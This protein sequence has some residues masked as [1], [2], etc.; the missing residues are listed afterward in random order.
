MFERIKFLRHF[1]SGSCV[2]GLLLIGVLALGSHGQINEKN[3]S[4]PRPLQP[5]DQKKLPAEVET[6]NNAARKMYAEARSRELSTIP[7]V[8]LVSGDDLILRK[9]GLRTA[10]TTTPIAVHLLKSV[11]HSTLALFTHL[12]SEPG[13]PL[14]KERLKTLSEYQALMAAAILPLERFGLEPEL[15]ARQKRILARAQEFAA[16]VL[17][18]GS[19]SAS[20]L[21]MFCR[22][23]RAD[24]MANG[25][26]AA[27][28]QMVA[29]HK[30][31]LIWKQAMTPEEW[32][33]VAVVVSGSQT[34]RA[35]NAA[36]QY[37]ARLFG[38]SSGESRR[39]VYAES[40]WDEDKAINL[41][42]TLRLDGK[43]S[44]AV[45]GDP[46]RMYRDFLA[47]GARSALD[48]IFAAP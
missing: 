44:V 31:V 20:D 43:L 38:E 34:P 14:G 22:A 29:L 30:Q 7:V 18:E 9:N 46:Y 32:S 37:F 17:Q 25:A 10:V 6:L 11:S 21:A 13:Q 40:L 19:V 26:A 12:S 3:S 36:V 47:D 16:K 35:D 2:L 42:G 5:G 4:A 48:E 8:I 15:L 28:A 24:I 23:S 33:S 45:F 41:L 27:K 39:I 1:K